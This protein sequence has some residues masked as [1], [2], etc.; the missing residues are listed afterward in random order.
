MNGSVVLRVLTGAALVGVA[1]VHLRIAGTYS[2]LGNHP[3]SLGD[4]FY[5]QAAIA[6]V[7]TAV[8]LVRPRLLV[9]VAAALFAAGSLAVLVYSRYR[10]IPIPGVP[11]GFQESWAAPS[12]KLAA[13]FETAALVF[14]LLGAAVTSTRR[15]GAR[16]PM[17]RHTRR[18]GLGRGVRVSRGHG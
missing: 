12:A 16:V 13:A 14:A 2:G 17:H 5:A 6:F 3:V 7:L 4:Q 15:R 8:L 1:V 9:W 18:P 10:T 11:G